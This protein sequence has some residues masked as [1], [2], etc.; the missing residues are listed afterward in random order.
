MLMSLVNDLDRS[1]P[2][3]GQRTR[4]RSWDWRP[5][6]IAGVVLVVTETYSIPG[7][8]YSTDYPSGWFV[9]T[10][11]SAT[12]FTQVEEELFSE[13]IA[14]SNEGLNVVVEHQ[15]VADLQGFGLASDDP[16][17]EDLVEFNTTFLGPT[18]ARD[19][20]E[21]E[22]F[23]SRAV[24]VRVTEADGGESVLYVGIR[25]DVGDAFF[26]SFTAASSE[27]LEEFGPTWDVMFDSIKAVDE[28][29]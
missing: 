4:R 5:L 14:V 1:E 2:V 22:V 26:L 12:M 16:T 13:S 19:H 28:A 9:E 24:R 17:A 27:I 3:V 15:T 20:E 23:G 11:Q 10:R 6:A 8:G 7:F 25:S 21:A 18:D 29:E